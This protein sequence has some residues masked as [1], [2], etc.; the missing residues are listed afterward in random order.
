MSRLAQVPLLA[1][2]LLVAACGDNKHPSVSADKERVEIPIGVTETVAVTHDGGDATFDPDLTWVVDDPGIANVAWNAGQLMVTGRAVGS[3]KAHASYYGETVE[4]TVA[5]DEAAFQGITLNSSSIT[6]PVGDNEPL[7]L[8]AHMTDGTTIDVTALATW[9]TDDPTI[10]TIENG[11]VH[12]LRAGSTLAHASYQGATAT[13]LITV[14]TAILASLTVDPPATTIPIGLTTTFNAA[15]VMTDNTVID[16]SNTVRWRTTNTAIATV[17]AD[18]RVTGV[19][20]GR[21]QVVA[22][23]GE[24]SAAA[25]VTV[26][27]ITITALIVTPD[28]PTIPVTH[29]QQLR[30][31]VKLSDGS[32]TDV[33]GDVTWTS[34]NPAIATVDA[35]GTVHGVATGTTV[36]TAQIGSLTTQVTVTVSSATLSRVEVRPNPIVMATGSHFQATATGIFSDGI[37]RDVTAEAVWSTADG[38]TA[39]VAHGDLTGVAAGTTQVTA[40]LSGKSDAATVLV[41]AAQPTTLTVIAQ[42]TSMPTGAIQQL[43]A[44]ATYSDGSTQDVTSS[45]LWTSSNILSVIVSNLLSHGVATALLPGDATITASLGLLTGSVRLTV[46][47]ATLSRIDLTPSTV[48][49]AVAA[50]Q[51]VTATAV[52]SDGTTLDVTQLALWSSSANATATVSNAPGAGVVTGVAVGNATISALFGGVTGTLPVAVSAATLTGLTVTPPSA[53]LA[54]GT[55]TQLT[56]TATYSDSSHAD[57]T[58]QVVWSTSAAAIANV[59]NASGTQGKVT[60]V[61][62][63]SATITATLGAT[64]AASTITVTPATLAELQLTPSSVTVAVGGAADVTATGVYSDG[65]TQNLTTQVSWSI[66]APSTATVENGHVVGV[67]PGGA[68]LTATLGSVS[69]T[70]AVTVTAATV[71][72]L[73]VTPPTLNLPLLQTAQLTATGT[74]SDTTTADVTQ[75]ATWTSSNP[76]VA[77]V[78]NAAGSRGQVTSLLPG[79]AT[80]TATASGHTATATVTVS[81]AVLTS[82]A[83]SPASISVASGLST[84]AT[85]IGTFSDGTTIDITPQAQ[86]TSSAPGVL[87]VGLN[88]QLTAKSAGTATLTATVGLL[89]ATASATVTS[90]V[91]SSIAISPLLP[92]L[93][94]G[95]TERMSATATL[96]DGTHADVTADVTWTSSFTA[97]ATISN[98]AEGNG[99]VTSHAVGATT[100]TATLNGKS[101]TVLLT[102]TPAQLAQLQ[103]TPAT[104]TLPAGLTADV[105]ATGVFSD[106]TTHDVSLLTSWGSAAPAVATVINGH[107]TAVAPGTTTITATVAGVSQTLPI[108]VTAATLT[109]ITVTPTNP[110]VA[111]L[112]TTPLT[113]TATYSD[114]STQNITNQATWTSSNVLN[115]TVTTLGTPRGVVTGLL[116]GAATITAALGGQSASVTVTVTLAVVTGISA[117]T[118]ALTLPIGTSAPITVLGQLSDGTTIDLTSQ[119]TFSSTDDSVA[120]VSASGVVSARAAGT[121][122]VSATV[123]G[124]TV[125]VNVTVS[126]IALSQLEISPVLTELPLGVTKQMTATGVYSDG[127]HA[128]LTSQVTWTSSVPAAAT[129]SNVDAGLVTSQ[130][131]GATTITA[132]IN[133]MS[134]TAALAVTPAQLSQIQLTPATLTLPAGLSADLV[135]TGVYSDGTMHDLTLLVSWSSSAPGTASVLLGHVAATTPGTATIT[136]GL[137]ALSATAN[138]TVTTAELTGIAVTP[139]APSLAVGQSVQMTATGT[140]SDG[141]SVNLT[142]QVQ[143]TSSNLLVGLISILPGSQGRVTA[144]LPGTTLV[145]ATSGNVSTSVTVTVSAAQLTSVAITPGTLTV[146]SGLSAPLALSGTYSDGSVV[147]LSSQAI[148]TS[149]TPGAATVS[150]NGRVTGQAPGAATITATAGGLSASANVNI[151]AATL[152]SLTVA[153]LATVLPLGIT[154]H[155][156]ATGVYSDGSH[157]DLTNEVSW[158]SSLPAFATVSNV[159]AA[160]G[161]VTP[162]ALGATTITAALGGQSATALVTVTP[163]ALQQLQLTPSSL[164]L[165]AGV[166]ADVVA[167]GVYSDGSTHDLTP[168]AAWSSSA[169]TTASVLAGHVTALTPGSAVITVSI[170]GVTQTLPVTVSAAQLGDLAVDPPHPVLSLGQTVQLTATGTYGDNTTA[171]VTAQAL[172]QS[173]NPLVA[174]VSNLPGSRGKV[175]ALLSGTATLTATLDGATANVVVTVTPAALLS[176]QVAP[177]NLTMPAG[178]SQQLTVTGSYSDLTTKDLTSQ[179]T[180][181]TS[182]P[183]AA[184]VSN[185]GVVTAN[186]AGSA[187]I[188]ATVGAR[189][190]ISAVTVSPAVLTALQLSPASLNIPLGVKSQLSATGVYSDGSHADATAS[191]TWTSSAPSVASV[192]N[193]AGSNGNVTSNAQGDATIT[194]A[195][196]AVS[197]TAPVHVGSASLLSVSVVG[198][199]GQLPL[200]LSTALKAFG[201]YTDGS[202]VDLT[203]QA[204]FA[205]TTPAITVSNATGTKGVALAAALGQSVVSATVGG[206][207][208]ELTVGTTAAQLQSITVSTPPVLP[209]GLATQLTATG[210]YSDGSTIDLTSQVAWTSSAPGVA[211]VASGLLTPL[212]VGSATVTASLGGV[213]AT[214]TVGTSAASLTSI[215]VAPTT[216]SLALGLTAQLTATG[217]YTDGT[218]QD[219]TS[220]ATWVSDQP[221]RAG[222]SNLLTHGVVTGLLGGTAHITAQLGAVTSGQATVT[223]TSA[224]LVSVTVSPATQNI[225]LG[226]IAPLTATANYSDG[227][228]IDVTAAAGWLS[229]NS[230][231]VAV[232]NLAGQQGKATAL[233]AGS[234]TISATFQLVT[235]TAAVTVVQGCHLVINEVKT[236]TLLASRDEFVEVFNPC[237]FAIDVS[238]SRLAYRAALGLVDLALVDLTGTMAAG[239]YRVYGGSGYTGVSNGNLITDLAALGGGIAIRDTT[240][241]AVIDSMGYGTA[242]NLFVEGLVALAL[243]TGNSLSRIPNGNDSNNNSVDFVVTNPPTPGAANAAP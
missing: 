37:P 137:G 105:T 44:I 51:P 160:S 221:L 42:T 237:S 53:S 219:L 82:I 3:T 124:Q 187:T 96:S 6:T 106:G 196:G 10:A 232:S 238:H 206:V 83:I 239:S 26:S 93:P 189:S 194:A 88:G 108:T 138:V 211:T 103:L 142:S 14:T 227:A 223:V 30:A 240:S 201:T 174:T 177:A 178:L 234:A 121:A 24:I 205:S 20:A 217:H 35:D 154:T 202:V 197:A 104:L 184:S 59:S 204:T 140:Y 226:Q 192:S 63:G 215:T 78:S 17:D 233:Q 112:Q 8:L 231:N 86:I 31:V 123:A 170:A 58:A 147:D 157:T 165:P 230:A 43:K 22:S 166:A 116:P 188:T 115:A 136:A 144:L 101:A 92:S 71:T 169:P 114:G 49:L 79:T 156:T 172:W 139:S 175:L 243:P 68:T 208:G 186:A 145:T 41:T 153:P 107:V 66:N 129:V 89:T 109:S 61:A 155:L 183:A 222:V 45:V 62:V 15:G 56:A 168:L 13:V 149:S 150:A 46:T 27:G 77:S 67:A 2:V 57:V 1:V 39:T 23:V 4:V 84:Q 220:Q 21:T 36:V 32:N 218:T 122:A 11:Q 185:A 55:S 75:Q 5:V 48:S 33:T 143:W 209:L 173:S 91:V 210:N 179:A 193:V 60:T 29:A 214:T 216:L 47:A 180:F 19:A 81:V 98:V 117:G 164:S 130:A 99:Q 34:A 235:G 113:A 191:V 176:V 65:T 64:T 182:A 102:V 16:I 199:D 163:A 70:A 76:L 131:L 94:L 118:A 236:G 167:T 212:G 54:L 213:S 151:T 127:S 38:N 148:W 200:G 128:D 28:G 119:A 97:V 69:V 133:N 132:T 73:T 146:P 158:T 18:G 181:T 159:G 95:T 162:Q 12:G 7:F 120:A 72:S 225:A 229:S 25:D 100:I 111:L 190:A 50:Q 9:T 195:L 126:G 40:T 85:V 135:A 198:Q 87:E 224:I 141:S 52:Y 134:A 80:I 207:T 203:A 110:T 241:N 152:S 171:D 161:E 242:I 228:A 90:A 125:T 74:L